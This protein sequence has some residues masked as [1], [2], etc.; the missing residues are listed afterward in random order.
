MDFSRIEERRVAGANRIAMAIVA[1]AALV[2]AALFLYPKPD[3]Y[4]FKVVNGEVQRFDTATGEVLVCSGG[5][6][7]RVDREAMPLPPSPDRPAED[8]AR[9][10]GN[11]GVQVVNSHSSE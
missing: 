11:L 8:S 9:S 5:S 10:L 2:A 1:A 4:E 6:C 7:F 3:R